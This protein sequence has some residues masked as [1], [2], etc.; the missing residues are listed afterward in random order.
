MCVYLLSRVTPDSFLKYLD[1]VHVLT[2]YK[3]LFCV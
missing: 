1:F 3:L 2:I